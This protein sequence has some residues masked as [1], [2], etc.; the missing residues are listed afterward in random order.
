M[1]STIAAFLAGLCFGAAGAVIL[2]AALAW[3]VKTM[4]ENEDNDNL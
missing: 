3:A 2:M 1:N 4:R